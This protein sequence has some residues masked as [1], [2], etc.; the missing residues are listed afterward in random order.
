MMEVGGIRSAAAAH[1]QYSSSDSSSD[2][3]LA[4]TSQRA[5][6]PLCGGFGACPR[7]LESA[8]AAS[9]SRSLRHGT[10]LEVWQE[11]LVTPASGV[12]PNG[13]YS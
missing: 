11:R 9:K 2:W 4:R 8:K 7:R 6:G 12:S 5:E 3:G 10:H 1:A 13:Q